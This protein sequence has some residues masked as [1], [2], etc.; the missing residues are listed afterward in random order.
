MSSWVAFKPPRPQCSQVLS[1]PPKLGWMSSLIFIIIDRLSPIL[2]SG[3]IHHRLPSSTQPEGNAEGQGVLRL[4][5]QINQNRSSGCITVTVFD[6][7][8]T[9]P[10]ALFCAL[11]LYAFVQQWPASHTGC[12]AHHTVYYSTSRPLA[13]APARPFLHDT[14]DQ[15]KTANF[16]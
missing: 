13:R 3:R 8:R 4:P 15:F 10:I 6:L 2:A 1:G 9:L 7:L 16:F 11:L 12:A 14:D 5:A